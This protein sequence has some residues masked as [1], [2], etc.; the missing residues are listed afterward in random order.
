MPAVRP[1]TKAPTP[2]RESPPRRRPYA[3]AGAPFGIAGRSAEDQEKDDG[4]KEEGVPGPEGGLANNQ[5]LSLSKRRALSRM[6]CR[7]TLD[8]RTG[9]SCRDGPAC[10]SV[11]A[12][13]CLVAGVASTIAMLHAESD[14]EEFL[15][16]VGLPHI[17]VGQDGRVRGNARVVTADR[18]TAPRRCPAI[19]ILGGAQ[20]RVENTTRSVCQPSFH[21]L[22]ATDAAST[23]E[24]SSVT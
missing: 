20:D 13:H 16:R 24:S 22:S 9:E 18:P 21:K 6:F 19:G 10:V 23:I 15:G 4:T 3:E 17:S 12:D 11:T 5:E 2:H 14:C 7:R 8:P 1:R